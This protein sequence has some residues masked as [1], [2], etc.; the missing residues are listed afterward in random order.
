MSAYPEP[1]LNALSISNEVWED[2][3]SMSLD[4]HDW[5][6]KYQAVDCEGSTKTSLAG[7]KEATTFLNQADQFKT[8]TKRKRGPGVSAGPFGND[9][10]VVGHDTRVLP[11]DPLQQ[12]AT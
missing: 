11:E 8:P 7:V 6:K 10:V 5:S 12:I 4:L 1:Y 3:K 2:W 9:W